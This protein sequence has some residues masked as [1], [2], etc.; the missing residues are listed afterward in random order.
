MDYTKELALA[1]QHVRNGEKI[2][3]RQRERVASLK[4]KRQ[5]ASDADIL[6]DTFITSVE[7]LKRHCRDLAATLRQLE[8]PTHSR[9]PK[10]I[11]E[12]IGSTVSPN[13]PSPSALL[14]AKDNAD[15]SQIFR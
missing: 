6:L 5:D 3:A 1:E 10:D 15:G 13:S 11:S 8:L 14:P 12:L 4:S 2:V 9:P 7:L